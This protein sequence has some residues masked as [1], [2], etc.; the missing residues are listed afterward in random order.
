MVSDHWSPS[1][2]ATLKVILPQSYFKA[3]N[4]EMINMIENV[5]PQ[6]IQQLKFLESENEAV[7]EM[8][9]EVGEEEIVLLYQQKVLVKLG[10]K[11]VMLLI[12]CQ[13]I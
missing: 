6:V 3:Q 8:E 7:L 2:C 13:V 1:Y 4:V 5:C 12:I 9:W 10:R 11:E